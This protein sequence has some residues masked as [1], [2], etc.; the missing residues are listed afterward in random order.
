MYPSPE[1][2]AQAGPFGGADLVQ[3]RGTVAEM[4]QICQTWGATLA[5]LRTTAAHGSSAPLAVRPWVINPEHRPAWKRPASMR[6]ASMRPGSTGTASMRTLLPDLGYAAVLRAYESSCEL[7]VAA[8][9]VDE[10]WTELHWIHGNLTA[11]SVLVEHQPTLRVSFIDPHGL[12]LGDPAWDLA[13]AVDM[14]TWLSPRWRTTP[15][16]LVDYLILGYRRAA[17]PGR[18]YPAIQAVR[19]LATAMWVA[20]SPHESAGEAYVEETLEFWLN[21]ARAYAARVGCLM[22]VA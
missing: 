5:A 1:L 11:T 4:A 20:D 18:L 13:A 12:G 15:P 19:A 7:R 9:E 10:R 8:R 2:V 14:I 3:Q 6:T 21:R 17:G 16:P 22:S